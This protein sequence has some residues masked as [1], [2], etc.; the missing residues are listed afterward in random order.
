MKCCKF[1]ETG[2]NPR[3]SCGGDAFDDGTMTPREA[4][5]AVTK[6][7]LTRRGEVVTDE[8]AIERA[9]NI[10]TVFCEYKIRRMGES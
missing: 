4:V 10:V 2:G 1:H 9:R 7:I 6:L 5:E 3:E 8:L